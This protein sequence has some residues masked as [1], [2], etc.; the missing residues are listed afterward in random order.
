MWHS[1]LVVVAVATF[2][3]TSALLIVL[4]GPDNVL[5]VRNALRY[6]RFVGLRTAAGTL[7]SVVIW[8]LAAAFG[9]SALLAAS[10]IGYDG[11]RV[12]GAIYLVWLGIGSLRSRGRAAFSDVTSLSEGLPATGRVGYLMG[13]VSN[14]ANHI[15]YQAGRRGDTDLPR[16]AAWPEVAGRPRHGIPTRPRT[17]AFI[18][19]PSDT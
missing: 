15:R 19:H 12:L 3:A 9:L 14:L 5:V 2:A 16:F 4:P 18:G 6:G 13:V 8:V 1:C 11:L 17:I 7:T 10:R